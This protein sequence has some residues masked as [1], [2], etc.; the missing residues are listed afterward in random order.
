M[1]LSLETATSVCSV[2]LLSSE[3]Q[4]LAAH[5]LYTD[6]PHADRLSVLV[7]QL[8]ENTSAKP[9]RLQ[10][11]V[12]SE[13]PGSYTGLRIGTSLAK[14]MC[15]ALGVPLITVGTLAGLAKAAADSL[16]EGTADAYFVP[17]L[18][19]RRME[20]YTA[21]FDQEGQEQ[22]EVAAE[23][24]EKADFQT[25]LTARPTY[26]FGDG[27]AKSR[28]FLAHPNARLLPAIRPTA[29]A[30][31]VLGYKK[32]LARTFADLAYFEPFYLKDFQAIKPRKDKLLGN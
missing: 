15:Y 13:G 10:G 22:R 16:A 8:L 20:V 31:G 19:A 24:L 21:V 28:P 32:Y 5:H 18:D 12:I 17:L 14:G 25:W 27:L 3:G 23:V 29:A 6:R 1:L 30:V 2:A 7:T 9:T 4:L 26:F 11:I